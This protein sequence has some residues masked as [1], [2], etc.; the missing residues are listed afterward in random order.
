MDSAQAHSHAQRLA[1][2]TDQA[3]GQDGGAGVKAQVGS[4]LY[5]CPYCDIRMDKRS[6]GR[7]RAKCRTSTPTARAHYLK[8]RVWLPEEAQID[9]SKCGRAYIR[10]SKGRR[11]ADCCAAERAVLLGKTHIAPSVGHGYDG[12]ASPSIPGRIDPS[13]EVRCPRKALG[14][15][16]IGRCVAE[17]DAAGCA[18]G[19]VHGRCSL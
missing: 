18:D 19:C 12:R 2:T 13:A 14:L 5:A 8:H 11:C 16:A 10:R 7:H 17:R 4:A 15:I 3:G 1:T 6:I 9:C